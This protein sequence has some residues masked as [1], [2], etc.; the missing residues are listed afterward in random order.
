MSR[1]RRIE[2][3]NRIFFVTT[4]LAPNLA[5]LSP[6][7]RDT[8]LDLLA[9]TRARHK[10]LLLGYVV[11]PNHAHILLATMSSP[12]PKIVQSW[13][14]RTALAINE[15]RAKTGLVWQARYFDFICRR[16]HDVSDKLA[17]IHQNP[18]AAGLVTYPNEW[19]W[20]SA[21]FYS[22]K[23]TPTLV[24]DLMDF[25]G[26]RDELLWPAPWRVP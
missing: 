14:I 8:V 16:A 12:L 9:Q 21:S 1:L 20:S 13:K 4:N 19:K 10:F 25:S 3:N 6:C 22:K 5:H 15:L 26:D 2:E 17:Y 23:G 18:V 24:P 11:M 7:E